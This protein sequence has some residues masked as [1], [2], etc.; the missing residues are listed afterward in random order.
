VGREWCGDFNN[1]LSVVRGYTEILRARV[2]PEDAVHGML[3][4]IRHAADREAELTH[5]LLAFSRRQV[6]E[7]KVVKLGVLVT[8]MGTCCG[9]WSARASIRS[10]PGR[11]R[12]EHLT[13]SRPDLRG[14]FVSAYT[15]DLIARVSA[16][17]RTGA[18]ASGLR[19]LQ[20]L[21]TL[22]S[23]ASGVR[24]ALQSGSRAAASR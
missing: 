20:K 7:P 1:L 13:R 3:E 18:L 17:G 15:D 14:L 9:G 6:L 2:P 19:F 16:A 8:D 22:G 4:T 12:A 24:E 23:L 11:Q 21:F 10:W 5:Q